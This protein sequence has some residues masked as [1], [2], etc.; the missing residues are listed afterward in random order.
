MKSKE[1]YD[2][3]LN[4]GE[5]LGLDGEAVFTA[6]FDEN[7]ALSIADKS[8]AQREIFKIVRQLQDQNKEKFEEQV[9]KFDK[10]LKP[11]TIDGL[12]N[13]PDNKKIFK[14][15]NGVSYNLVKEFKSTDGNFGIVGFSNENGEFIKPDGSVS[16]IT[17]APNSPVYG[18]RLYQPEDLKAN[19]NQIET[20]I[21]NLYSFRG[22]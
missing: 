19:N 9:A 14:S 8:K 20:K 22:Q 21:F 12:E 17:F 4:T 3:F 16:T 15:E 6:K 13:L 18:L 1:L 2:N 7:G 5:L 11:Y 10:G